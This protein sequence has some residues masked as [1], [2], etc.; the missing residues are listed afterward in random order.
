MDGIVF[1]ESV[2]ESSVGLPRW[3]SHKKVWGDKIVGDQTDL[4]DFPD[5]NCW[6]LAC[7]I[8]VKVDEALKIRGGDTPIG[9]YFVRYED[10]Y[11]SWSPA[12]VFE[13]GYT[14]INVVHE[15]KTWPKHFQATLDGLKLFELRRN[16][17][18][19]RFQ[20]GDGLLLREWDPEV[21][22]ARGL[23]PLY[24]DG[25]TATEVH[26]EAIEAAYTGRQ[27]LV[28]VNYIMDSQQIDEIGL[29]IGDGIG[30]A[31]V[32]MSVSLGA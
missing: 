6:L 31:F 1:K 20:V 5:G 22:T 2:A 10:G 11:E 26:E 9:G 25:M 18:V 23:S 4:E 14:R 15:V 24:R 19:P 28:Q 12:K 8:V 29:T 27:V 3:Q 16:D 17:R 13:E 32:I 30:P 7:G 21:Y